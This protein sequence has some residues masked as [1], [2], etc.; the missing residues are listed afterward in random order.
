MSKLTPPNSQ[1]AEQA[2]LGA[3]LYQPEKFAEA[4]A[5]LRAEDFYNQ[6]HF[7]IFSAMKF[8]ADKKEPID[9]ISVGE[10]LRD[11]S[12]LHLIGGSVYL[13][14]LSMAVAT[15]ENIGYYARIVKKGAIKRRTIK[16]CQTVIYEAGEDI[17][18]D[19]ALKTLNDGLRELCQENVQETDK[20]PQ[21]LVEVVLQEL[22]EELNSPGG[23]SG[24]RT[25]FNSLD[26]ITGGLKAEHLIII[27]ASSSMGKSAFSY[28][29]A[30]GVARSQEKTVLFFSL[31]MGPKELMRRGLHAD[32]EVK[33][34]GFNYE[35]YLKISQAGEAVSLNLL[36]LDRPG[37][38]IS[39]LRAAMLKHQQSN[40]L[41]LVVIDYLQLMD[42]EGKKHSNNRNLELGE[43]TRALKALAREYKIPIVALSQLNRE[44]AK[45]AD[46]RPI[47]SD[48]RD[49]G[50][51]EQDADDVLFLYRDEY[52]TKD[53][54]EK[55]GI[56]ELIIA[57]QRAGQLATL[58]LIFRADIVKFIEPKLASTVR[59]F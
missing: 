30:Q 40:G 14:D 59:I 58:D 7:K 57:K 31:E 29:L 53:K 28:N 22:M 45:R 54:C 24:L 13:M 32:A 43:I 21:Q 42:S 5:A 12:Q 52:Y 49:S 47:L 51:I 36:L 19:G 35:G 17:D 50:S 23:I 18:T 25:G 2:V 26:N 10:Y 4:S 56:T 9:V 44:V 38:K 1:E 3:I 33:S 46:K 16:L 15:A 27:G 55:P 41:A 6:N 39:Q 20:T 48:L 34:R 37:L 11:I 8:L